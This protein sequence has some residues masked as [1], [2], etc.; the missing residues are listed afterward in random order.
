MPKIYT[1]PKIYYEN[2]LNFSQIY[3]KTGV[4]DIVFG[5][6]TGI[7]FDAFEVDFLSLSEDGKTNNS[8]TGDSGT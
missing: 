8:V 6:D 1:F 5:D 3:Q 4:P 7:S 2:I